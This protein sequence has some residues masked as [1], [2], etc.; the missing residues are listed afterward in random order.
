MGTVQHPAEFLFTE[1]HPLNQE[2]NMKFDFDGGDTLHIRVEAP[3][4]FAHSDGVHVHS[5]FASLMLDTVMG[6]CAIGRL[7]KPQ[8]LAT[9]KLS[10]SHLKLPEIGTRIICTAHFKGIENSIAYADGE[11][12][13]EDNGET[14]ST[15]S[16]TFMIGT[17]MKS[18]REKTS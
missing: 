5:G 2:L 1:N 9:V 11:I 13:N 7:D 12:V 10:S 6:A 8:P 3:K 14:L 17:T 18:I 15:G 4:V 16:A